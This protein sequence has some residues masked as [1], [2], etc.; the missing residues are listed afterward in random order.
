MTPMLAFSRAPYPPTSA[1]SPVRVLNMVVFP[2]PAKP[3]SPTFMIHPYRQKRDPEEGGYL[4]FSICDF[5]FSICHNLTLFIF[6][7]SFVLPRRT[8]RPV[9]GRRPSQVK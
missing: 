1:V 4:R 8:V 9:I 5:L 3:T 2:D 7:L 6:H